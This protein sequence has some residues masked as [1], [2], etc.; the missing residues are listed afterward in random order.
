MTFGGQR[1]VSD[2]SC[3]L[4]KDVF[5][6]ILGSVVIWNF[7]CR[8]AAPR[9]VGS[10]KPPL[11]LRHQLI[12]ALRLSNTYPERVDGG[13]KLDR[14]ANCSKVFNNSHHKCFLAHFALRLRRCNAL[15]MDSLLRH[16][17]LRSITPSRNMFPQFLN[18]DH[19]HRQRLL[20]H[21]SLMATTH[22]SHSPKLVEQAMP[23]ELME[24]S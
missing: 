16:I 6:V 22:T 15:H 4:P 7:V 3:S 8:K 10:S 19:H 2:V 1:W 12:I 14:S 21:N 17:L 20:H 9:C 18:Y 13:L 5:R 24:D 23:S 11:Y